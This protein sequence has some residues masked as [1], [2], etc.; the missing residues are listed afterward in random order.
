MKKYF[1]PKGLK[2]IR[3]FL[4]VTAGCLIFALAF[5]WF[6]EPMN[7]NPGGFSGLAMVIRQ[8]IKLPIGLWI[9]LLNF[10]LVLTGLWKLGRKF[11]LFSAYATVL[12]SLLID[13]FSCLPVFV[14]DPLLASLYGGLL[15]GAGMGLILLGGAS[16]GGSDILSKILNC[17]FPHI[18]LG[19]L[20]L[21][22]DITVI[23]LS[24]LV[25]G[26]LNR[27]LYAAI[28]IYVN[29]VVVDLLLYGMDKA[30]LN[31]IMSEK[32]QEIGEAIK[33]QLQRGVTYI[34][35]HGG[36]TG[37]ARQV[38]MCAIRR[39]E[40]VLLYD[41]VI[42]IDPS[43]FIIAN[44]SHQVYGYGFSQYSKK[45]PEKHTSKARS[46]SPAFPKQEKD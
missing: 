19:Y 36:Y 12:S 26:D 14:E 7:I 8:F 23:S 27:T 45:G 29:S 6:L 3:E 21:A 31:Y 9:I 42:S 35:A 25:F 2:F 20:L 44:D 40:S 34:D 41:L 4:Q 15:L 5:D 43:A 10:P 17:F 30:V 1:F 22:I 39:N 33:K 38:V 37:Q 16:T 11:I 18:R 32:W 24:A 28:T 13:L 46:H